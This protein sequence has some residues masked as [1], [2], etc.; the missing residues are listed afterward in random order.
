LE[1]RVGKELL[2]GEGAQASVLMVEG[3]EYQAI[4]ILYHPDWRARQAQW[5]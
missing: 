2:N 3:I 1:E 5:C 4:R